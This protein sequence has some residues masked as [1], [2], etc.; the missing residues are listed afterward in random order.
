MEAGGRARATRMPIPPSARSSTATSSTRTFAASTA[1]RGMRGGQL[2]LRTSPCAQGTW[3]SSGVARDHQSCGEVDRCRT[4]GMTDR[5][6]APLAGELAMHLLNWLVLVPLRRAVIGEDAWTDYYA[7]GIDGHPWWHY[8]EDG[9]GRLVLVGP[10]GTPDPR[11][12][13]PAPMPPAPPRRPAAGGVQVRLACGRLTTPIAGYTPEA[14][15][16]LLDCLDLLCAL[17]DNE[18]PQVLGAGRSAGRARRSISLSARDWGTRT[19]R[20]QR[21]ADRCLARLGADG[22][23]MQTR[24]GSRVEWHLPSDALERFG[25]AHGFTLAG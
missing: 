10:I 12:A 6:L 25:R 11:E 24:V 8:A 1:V 2:A 17:L 22:I 21:R 23:L 5:P 4:S 3:S 18:L 9:D 20:S 19:G 7:H 16:P 14:H 15:A 13:T